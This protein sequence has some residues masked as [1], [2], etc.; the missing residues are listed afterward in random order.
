MKGSITAERVANQVMML[1]S[2]REGSFL[3]VEGATDA[4]VFRGLIDCDRCRL[5]IAHS[6]HNAAKAIRLLDERGLKGALAVV[7]ADYWVLEAVRLGSPNL[8]LTDSHD[9][10]TMLLRSPALERVI[11]EYLP[12]DELGRA[13]SIAHRVREGLLAVGVPLGYLRWVGFRRQI[14]LNVNCVSVEGFVDLPELKVDLDRLIAL[15]KAGTKGLVLSAAELRRE[16]EALSRRDG[17]PWHIV[18]GHDLIEIMEVALPLAVEEALGARV[19]QRVRRKARNEKMD[20]DLRLAYRPSF[21]AATRLYVSI[22]RWEDDNRPY[23]IL[24]GS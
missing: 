8:L 6:K 18:Q 16:V 24:I 17:D 15:V 4:K 20:E 3:L 9:L 7:D 2:Q 5:V 21:F 13:D 12:G 1:R 19:A 14:G 11:S 23:V 10:E 22:R